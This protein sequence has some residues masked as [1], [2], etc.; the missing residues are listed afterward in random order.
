L[1]ETFG[2]VVIEAMASGLPVLG[3]DEAAVREHIQ[4][5]HNGVSVE[6]GNAEAFIAAGLD[7]TRKTRLLTEYGRQARQDSLEQDWSHIFQKFESLLNEIREEQPNEPAPAY[8]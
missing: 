4:T 8:E 3:Y 5:E 2:N 7:M 6:P 1:S